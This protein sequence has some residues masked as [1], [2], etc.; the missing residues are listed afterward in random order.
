MLNFSPAAQLFP[1]VSTPSTASHTTARHGATNQAE[2]R[3]ENQ[4]E[5][6]SATPAA[7]ISQK[8]RKHR[9]TGT[10][11][12]ELKSRSAT[13]ETIY[14]AVETTITTPGVVINEPAT[15]I[16]EPVTA[17]RKLGAS[18]RKLGATTRKPGATT[19]KPGATTRKLGA[20][21]RKL[22]VNLFVSRSGHWPVS[23]SPWQ[24]VLLFYLFTFLLFL[25]GSHHPPHRSHAHAPE[26]YG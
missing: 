20:T 1:A 14:K 3:S 16:S 10:K 2:E 8:A 9:N 13:T 22:K 4:Q 26:R 19:R 25:A 7:T 21:T 24:C 5:A 17:I 15:V 6:T 12:T 11:N 23:G 18:I